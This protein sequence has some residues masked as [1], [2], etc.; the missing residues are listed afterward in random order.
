MTSE[1]H[2]GGSCH[3]RNAVSPYRVGRTHRSR[4]AH[5]QRIGVMDM[6]GH[7][8]ERDP[9]QPSI[10]WINSRKA[11]RSTITM[12]DVVPF[13]IE[14]GKRIGEGDEPP[15]EYH[16]HTEIY[17]RRPDVFSIVHSHPEHILTLSA[18]GH[19]LRQVSAICPFLPAE[20]APLFDSAVLINTKER[21]TA[22]ATVLGDA[23]AVV[24][25]QHG[26]VVVGGSLEEAVVRMI[27]AEDNARLQFRTLQIGEPRYIAGEELAVL[28]KENLAPIIYRKFWHYHEESARTAGALDGITG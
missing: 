15:S 3:D 13:D 18:A 17:R 11:S 21:G 14:A 6:N 8:S 1:R 24:L 25:R 7:V 20:G 5:L 23:G 28:K 26:T 2:I 10:M 12:N 27:C 4:R 22:V 9:D 19:R 16:I